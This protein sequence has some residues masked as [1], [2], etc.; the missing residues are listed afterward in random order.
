MRHV[1]R[2]RGF[3]AATSAATAFG[4]APAARADQL[5]VVVTLPDLAYLAR[6][7][8]GDKVDVTT[9]VKGYQDPHYVEAK[10]SLMKSVNDA[11]LFVEI[12]MQLELWTDRV[13]EGANNPKVK[14]GQPGHVFASDN[15]PRLEVPKVLTRAQG[16]LHPFGNPHIWLDPLNM[17]IMATNVADGLKRVDPTNTAFYDDRCKALRDKLD[18]A[19]FGDALVDLLKGETLDRLARQGK[20]YEFLEG[21]D[22]KGSKLITKL[23]GW[24]KQAE[25]LRGQK[26]VHFHA[27][28]IYFDERFGLSISNYIEDKPGIPTSAKHKEELIRQMKDE[29]IKIVECTNYY[30]PSTAKA[31]CNDTGAALVILPNCTEGVPEASDYVKFIS[32]LIENLRKSIGAP[33]ASE[34]SAPA[35]QR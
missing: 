2:I 8:G 7:I 3:V 16:D 25:P 22:Y 31:I 34:T 20:L 28:W 9:L 1:N 18:R 11:D 27:S 29:K 30:E 15:V 32:Y 5:K 6:E 26:I 23:G 14:P 12:G 4:L 33:A 19:L 35:G 13:F 10:P 17:K 21:H 24:L